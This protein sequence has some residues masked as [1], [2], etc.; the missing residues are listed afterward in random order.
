[1]FESGQTD[2][3]NAP[4]VYRTYPIK[5][6]Y[7]AHRKVIPAWRGEAITI[8][9][10]LARR[11]FLEEEIGTEEEFNELWMD[12]FCLEGEAAKLK[13]QHHPTEIEAPA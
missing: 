9:R 7:M 3:R 13:S 1:M 4:I 11:R 12:A 5:G 2:A 6:A 10:R 8:I